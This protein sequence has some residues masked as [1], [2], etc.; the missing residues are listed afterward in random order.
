MGRGNGTSVGEAPAG[1]ESAAKRESGWFRS[2]RRL[3]PLALIV[4]RVVAGDR[5]AERTLL[6]ALVPLLRRALGRVVSETEVDDVV[7]ESL[8]A[9]LKALPAFRSESTVRTFAL[10]I[11]ENRAVSRRRGQARTRSHESEL[12]RLEAPLRAS[13][14]APD[15]GLLFLGRRQ[16]VKRLVEALPPRQAT[17][18]LLRLLDHSPREIGKLTNVSVNTVRTR[19][20]LARQVMLKRIETDPALGDLLSLSTSG[21]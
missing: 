18:L 13:A 14:P 7:Q 15:D 12:E 5:R 1:D 4:A 19:L 6:D 21:T 3:D 10:R 17:A 8:L 9:V 2:T 16:L 20:R 11:A